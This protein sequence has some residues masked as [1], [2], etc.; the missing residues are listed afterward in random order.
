MNT[1]EQ[2]REALKHASSLR[3]QGY[4]VKITRVEGVGIVLEITD[5]EEL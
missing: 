3:K 1:E 5:K 4:K 2:E